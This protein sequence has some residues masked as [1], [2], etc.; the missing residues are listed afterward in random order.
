MVVL[1]NWD[2]STGSSQSL[3]QALTTEPLQLAQEGN[4]IA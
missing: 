3:I 4:V 1:R 2:L